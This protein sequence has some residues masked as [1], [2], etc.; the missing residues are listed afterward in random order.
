MFT[1]RFSVNRLLRSLKDQGFS[2]IL[3]KSLH[4]GKLKLRNSFLYFILF[5]ESKLGHT[6]TALF[7]SPLHR[8][9]SRHFVEIP[10]SINPAYYLWLLKHWPRHAD[11]QQMQEIV[12]LL[13]ATPLI[14]VIMPI[15][16][17]PEQFL[18]AAIESVIQ[19]VYPYWELC[20]ADDASIAAH[21]KPLLEQYTQ[22]DARIKV[23]YR[24]E[25]GHI[26]QCT[27]SAIE[28]AAGE[29]IALLDHDDALS[30][31]ALYE[32]ALL[33]NRHPNA[34]M[35]YSDEDKLDKQGWVSAPI[36][37]PDWCPDSFLARMYTCHLGVY[38]RSLVTKI[39]G[40]RTG[41]EGSQDYD[42]VLRF[43]EQTNQ[44]FHIPK[45]LYHWRIHKNSTARRADAKPYAFEAG[46]RAIAEAIQ[47]RGEPG[48]VVMSLRYPG[49]YTVQYAI[50]VPKKVSILIPSRN[51]GSI[52]DRCLNSIFSKST[53]PNFEVIVIDN[54]STEASFFQ[55]INRW[56]VQEPMRLRS[57]KLD[58]PFNY[59]VLNNDAVQ[60]SESEFLLLLNND[61]EVITNNWIEGMVAQAQR[62]S[63]G[64]VGALLRYPDNTIQH[65]GI[66]LKS[67]EIASHTHQHFPIQAA[68]YNNQIHSVNNVSAV[69]AACLMCRR[70]VFEEVGGFEETLGVAF[71][72]VDFCLKL[73]QKGYW[74]VYLPHVQLYHYESKSRGYEDTLEKQRRF[75]RETQYMRQTWSQQIA[76]DPCSSS[77]IAQVMRLIVAFAFEFRYG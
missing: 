73:R 61:T 33:L 70:Q 24:H 76:H 34:D 55:V 63:I 26:S 7:Q 65:A 12:E 29:Y 47:R 6:F 18:R 52:L 28:L 69:T 22:Q 31:N 23:V 5:S 57:Y 15:Y 58:I 40:F 67:Q 27:N 77:H 43:T 3:F 72:D 8:I 46:Q 59:S 19:Q 25:N 1:S 41:F 50:A 32:V 38:R 13:P 49:H 2:Y 30:P 56:A 66:E 64:A 71:N 48:D 14:S 17:T 21:I 4:K 45:V 68:G 9:L 74:N 16:N 37:K 62:P 53:Y 10:L 11:Y 20:I 60:K 42:F 75:E 39:G 51:L 36:F 44:I 35:V 54:G